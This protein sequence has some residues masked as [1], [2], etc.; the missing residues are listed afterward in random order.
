[1]FKTG[2]TELSI[3]GNKFTWKSSEFRNI[4][5]KLDRILVNQTFIFTFP[6]FKCFTLPQATSDHTPLTFFLDNIFKHN[7]PFIFKNGWVYE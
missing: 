1:M 6:N 7:F 5:C 2:L 3:K 4:H